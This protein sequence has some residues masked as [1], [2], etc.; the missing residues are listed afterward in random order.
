MRSDETDLGR[1]L[2]AVAVVNGYAYL[3]FFVFF[4]PDLST[5]GYRN[6]YFLVLCLLDSKKNKLRNSSGEVKIVG[7]DLVPCWAWESVPITVLGDVD[8]ARVPDCNLL[9]QMNSQWRSQKL[10]QDGCLMNSEPICLI[11]PSFCLN[12][13]FLFLKPHKSI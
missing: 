11:F 7:V 1:W 8:I 3:S 4:R 9:L 13:V 5:W 6:I 12:E 2:L 10:L